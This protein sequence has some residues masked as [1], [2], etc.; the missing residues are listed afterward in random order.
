MHGAGRAPN[1]DGLDL[2]QAGIEASRRG[3]TVGRNMATTNPRVY[4][5]GD[6]AATVQLARV[7][8]A[9]ALTAAANIIREHSGDGQEA[10]MNYAAAPSVL[11]TY[12]QY[13]MVGATERAL[14]D[15]GVAYEK[16]FGKNL[17][18]PTYTRVGMKSAAYKVLAG[19][20]GKI[21]G[22]HIL[23]DN[24][25]GL[26]NTFTLAMVNGISAAELHRQSIMTPYPSRE[27]D[28]IYMLRPLIR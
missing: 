20:G 11:F 13:G 14:E 5:A 12:P 9:E 1:I 23:S 7:A 19:D 2:D 22:A 6:C 8:D 21:L 15:Q 25:A 10:I 27:S 3:I 24:A 26:I 4:A 17:D 16:S 28:I 18:W